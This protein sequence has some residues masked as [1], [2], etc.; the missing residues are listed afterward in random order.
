VLVLAAFLMTLVRLRIR[1]APITPFELSAGF[2][3]GHLLSSVTEKAHLVTLLFVFAA[4]LSLEW[5][6]LRPGE[7]AFG[8]VRW[9]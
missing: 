6:T 5:R 8:A 1:A 9:C 3:V 2:L 4:F 7:R